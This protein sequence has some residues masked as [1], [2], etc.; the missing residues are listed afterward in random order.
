MVNKLLQRGITPIQFQAISSK[1]MSCME[2][3]NGI[4]SLEEHVEV[5]GRYMTKA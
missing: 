3:L 2:V 4:A 1:R 5:N